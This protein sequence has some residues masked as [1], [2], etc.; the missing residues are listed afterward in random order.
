M[1]KNTLPED[2]LKDGSGR[3]EHQRMK[4]FLVYMYLLK[5][6][7]EAHPAKAETIAEFLKEQGIFAERRAIYK[8]IEELNLA[9]ILMTEPDCNSIEEAAEMLAEDDYLAAIIYTHKKPKGFY[10]SRRPLEIED[11]MLLAQCIYTARFIPKGTETR[12][13]DGI[14]TFLS[15]N[16]ADKIYEDV[17]LVDRTKTNNKE[18]FFNVEQINLAKDNKRKI[19][20]KYLKYDINELKKQI[21]RKHGEN[22]TVSPYA[23]LINDGN[24]YLLGL[25]EKQKITTYRIDR[26]KNVNILE[27]T[28]REE[29]DESKEFMRHIESY[30][31][32]VFSMYGGDRQNVEIRF[33]TPLLDTVIDRFGTSAGTTYSKVDENHFS[34]RTSIEVSDQFFAWVCGFGKKAKITYPESV[35]TAFK[36]FLNKIQS[37]Y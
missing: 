21:E 13:L 18:I 4:H 20:F 7:D 23:V 32:R 31:R 10:M 24:Y 36:E 3:K 19:Q 11:A 5:Y 27:D 9:Y 17:Y 16:Q 33:I 2:N 25:N 1:A 35:V 14:S 29:T 34:V 6:T 26:M 30:A 28:P 15:E 37:I 22:Y 12:L 8:D